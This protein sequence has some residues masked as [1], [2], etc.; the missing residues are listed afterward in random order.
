[1]GDDARVPAIALGDEPLAARAW[2]HAQKKTLIAREQ[3]PEARAAW[4]DE[5]ATRD[6][7]SLIFLDETSTP[8]NLTPRFARARRGQRVLGRVPHGRWTSVTLLASLTPVGF[9]PG[10]QFAG[11]LDRQIFDA[12]VERIL[13]P[14]LHPGQTVV[15]D[16]LSV[17]KS[18]A[19][20]RLIEAAGCQLL[21]LPTYS[22][23]FNPI[24]QA[25]AKLKERLRRAEARTVEAVFDATHHAYP[26]ITPSDARSF[27]RDAGYNLRE[28]L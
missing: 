24:E 11:A 7:A 3:D 10:L 4:R 17:H 28:P 1:V 2:V 14:A 8:T 23:D 9:G 5:L 26:A 21:F 13:V 20:R 27:Y 22:P 12:F 19:A 6:P 25:F 15:L 18:A 16:N